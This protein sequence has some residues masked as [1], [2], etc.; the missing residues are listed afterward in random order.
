MG[1]NDLRER[2]KEEE[3]QQQ[4]EEEEEEE[5]EYLFPF[6]VSNSLLQ[7]HKRGRF[8]AFL[9]REINLQPTSIYSL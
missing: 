3:Q 9:H 1:S 4:E 6:K 7:Q 5:D 2:D 8:L